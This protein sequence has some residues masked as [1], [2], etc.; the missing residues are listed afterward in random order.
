MHVGHDTGLVKVKATSRTACKELIKFCQETLDSNLVALETVSLQYRLLPC[1]DF[2]LTCKNR[3]LEKL[4]KVIFVR[5]ILKPSPV[6]LQLPPLQLGIQNFQMLRIIG[7]GGFSRVIMSRQLSTGKLC[8]MKVMNKKEIIDQG[9]V[10]QVMLERNILV[11][12][13]HPYIVNLQDAFHTKSHLHLVLEFCPGGELFFHLNRVKK[14][15]EETARV[16]IAE[17]VLAVEFL[18]K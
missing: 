11:K 6:T 7:K 16:I 4:P 13:K 12:F 10:K 15:T 1:I 9:K 18:H 14:F 3:T 17:V 5:P 8:A 2:Y